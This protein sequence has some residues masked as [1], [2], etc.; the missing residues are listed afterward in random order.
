MNG[1]SFWPAWE[2]K[3]RRT[4]SLRSA[5]MT[6][7]FMLSAAPTSAIWCPLFK[8]SES[9]NRSDLNKTIVLKA[10]FLMLLTLWFPTTLSAWARTCG[11]MLAKARRSEPTVRTMT[12]MKP[13]LFVPRF[14]NT[15]TK[16][17]LL[18]ISPFFIAPTRSLVCLKRN[19]Q[20]AVFRSWFTAVYDSSIVLKLRTLWLTCAWPRTLQTILHS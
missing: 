9:E 17:S 2:K 1:W 4:R 11:R 18:K 19:W 6:S 8:S 13:A 12:L 7:R 14:R 20:D 10:T 3:I 5:T 15:S 16:A